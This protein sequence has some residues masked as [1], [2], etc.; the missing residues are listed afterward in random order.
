MLK[1]SPSLWARTA[2]FGTL[3]FALLAPRA[4][5]LPELKLKSFAEG[6]TSPIALIPFPDSKG[7]V[8]VAD[9]VGIVSI[10][11]RLGV[12]QGLPFLAL[13]DRMAKLNQGFD[14][15]GLLGLALHPDFTENGRL[16][17]YYSAPLRST[18]PPDW[19]HT[20]RISEFRVREDNSR[21][22]DPNSERVLLEFDQPYFNHNGGCI[23]FGPD[24]YLYIASGDG[25]NANG[26]GRGHSPIGNSQ[27]PTNLLGKI[28]RI[29]VNRS[30]PGRAYGIPE[31]NPLQGEGQK[32]EIYALG[33][34]NPWRITFDREGNHD[35][36]AADIGQTLYE[37]V[38][39]IRNGGNY[40]WNIR[41]GTH[42]F[43]PKN[44]KISPNDCPEK[45]L[46]GQPL[47]DP[48]LEYKNV[49]GFRGDPEAGGISVTGGYV[50]RGQA[51]PQLYGHYV[52]ADWTA[53]WA[54]PMGVL[55]HSD[56]TADE[57]P[58]SMDRLPLSGEPLNAYVTALGEDDQGELYIL[59][60]G[61][62]GLSQRKGK[63]Y[64]LVP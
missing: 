25:G 14:E 52:F 62:N 27:D 43:D 38:N 1:P 44:P 45:D 10:I 29:D 56:P 16:Y 50:Y 39:L 57:S 15:R 51:I 30:T 47:L 37:E 23:A 26:L 46:R 7:S 36:F 17:V 8:L 32:P 21:R 12:L 34:R 55:F 53:N 33:L 54:V 9:Q 19:D 3:I 49:N 5:E 18:A 61:L 4:A 31:D 58:W 64:K 42:C 41:E 2:A 63:V 59:T 28:L 35:L 22:V 48:V 40:G 13:S 60:N 6:F 11:S 24:G 20:S